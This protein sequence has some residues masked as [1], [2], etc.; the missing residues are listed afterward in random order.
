M[1]IRKTTLAALV[2][3]ASLCSVFAQNASE[4]PKENI[5]PT[6]VLGVSVGMTMAQTLTEL[7]S[8]A[9]RFHGI[10]QIK[11]N[12]GSLSLLTNLI[13]P[14]ARL[15]WDDNSEMIAAGVILTFYRGKVVSIMINGLA[16]EDEKYSA[17]RKWQSFLAKI[18]STRKDQSELVVDTPK[19]INEIEAC[20]I[21]DDVL[22]LYDA[23]NWN[24]YIDEKTKLT[25]FFKSIS[26]NNEVLD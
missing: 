25:E 19:M 10:P 9:K 15:G 5:K 23:D 18:P 1:K 3:F 21:E 16:E 12:D 4:K 17:K 11:A 26:R 6:T 7:Q 8:R 13:I 2:C 20:A 24:A 14:E 22:R